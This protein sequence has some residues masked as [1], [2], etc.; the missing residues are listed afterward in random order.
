MQAQYWSVIK[1]RHRVKLETLAIM[2]F[3]GGR[4][5]NTESHRM[6]VALQ[7]A[8]TFCLHLALSTGHWHVEAFDWPSCPRVEG[9]GRL[10]WPAVSLWDC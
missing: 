3:E 2:E 4:W 10:V 9:E 6:T 5:L 7:N 8:A 1:D